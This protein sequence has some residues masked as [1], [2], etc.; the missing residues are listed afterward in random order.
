ML[1]VHYILRIFSAYNWKLVPFDHLH[2]FSPLLP[3][4]VPSNSNLFFFLCF[5]FFFSLIPVQLIFQ[6]YFRAF[7]PHFPNAQLVIYLIY[8]NYFEI[9]FFP[10]YIHNMLTDTMLQ[11]LTRSIFD[12][13]QQILMDSYLKY[14]V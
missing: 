14:Y 3:S 13:V 5:F 12:S 11:Y 6:A 10:F 1:S 8:I 2:P 9:M 4:S 7:F